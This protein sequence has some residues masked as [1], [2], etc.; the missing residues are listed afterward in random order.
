MSTCDVTIVEQGGVAEPAQGRRPW[1]FAPALVGIAVGAVVGFAFVPPQP[2]ERPMLP[3]EQEV[4]D[5][6]RAVGVSA[7]AIRETRS[8]TV[9]ESAFPARDF[10]LGEYG[11]ASIIFLAF[12]DGAHDIRV[13]TAQNNEGRVVMVDGLMTSSVNGEPTVY[14]V[15][16]QYF[17]FAPDARAASVL[18]VGLGVKR[19]RC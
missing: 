19:A 5:R 6:L 8:D 16:S 10:S 7:V 15:S 3:R 4:L 14:L 2:H 11:D 13:C 18:E 1:W 9:L 12:V 17:V